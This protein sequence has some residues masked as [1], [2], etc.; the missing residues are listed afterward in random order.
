MLLT[1]ALAAFGP[2]HAFV[3][4]ATNSFRCCSSLDTFQ[5]AKP[6]TSLNAVKN[7]SENVKAGKK[8]SSF[9]PLEDKDIE[10]AMQVI[11]EYIKEHKPKEALQLVSG[12]YQA[13]PE[14]AKNNARLYE[15]AVQGACELA[16]AVRKRDQVLK[17]GIQ[18]A[19]EGL[20]GMFA[21]SEILLKTKQEMTAKLAA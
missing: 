17:Q 9:Q 3:P 13:A 21:N 19:E 12:L 2:V 10:I 15:C 8:A 4:T 14:L 11:D 7:G 5:S 1:A 6:T 16:D 18:L 20:E